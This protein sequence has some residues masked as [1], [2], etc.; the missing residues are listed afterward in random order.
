LHQSSGTGRTGV[1]FVKLENVL[2]IFQALFG[3]AGR[4]L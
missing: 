2:V 1:W 3:N 4:W